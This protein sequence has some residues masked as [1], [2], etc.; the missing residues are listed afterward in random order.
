VL[1][2]AAAR[3]FFSEARALYPDVRRGLVIEWASWEQ[4]ETADAVLGLM[5]TNHIDYHVVRPRTSPTN[6]ST[7]ASPSS[8]STGNAPLA[9]PRST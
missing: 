8:S 6:T 7:A 4:R 3:D 1:T 2:D 5:S 9:G